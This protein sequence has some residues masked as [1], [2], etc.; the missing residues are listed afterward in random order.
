MLALLSAG[1]TGM[2]EGEKGGHHYLS[3]DTPTKIE[4]IAG[5]AMESY[6]V[7]SCCLKCH[8]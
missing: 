2:L 6:G 7:L 3:G 8:Y 4:K 1:K 5:V